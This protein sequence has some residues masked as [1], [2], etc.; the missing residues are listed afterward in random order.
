MPSPLGQ[1]VAGNIDLGSHAPVELFAGAAPIITNS[2]PIAADVQEYQVVAL[3]AAG[4]IVP[5]APAAGDTTAVA[6]GVSCYAAVA[7]DND[8]V[9]IYEGAFFN[10]EALVW[11]A[12]L[13][14]LAQRRA[15][16]SATGTIK[17][18]ALI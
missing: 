8:A 15:V 1:R 16:F 10:H 4:A 3:N 2:R 13:T 14:T 6:V 5:H 9:S 12:T 7:A 11:D 18:G 17:I